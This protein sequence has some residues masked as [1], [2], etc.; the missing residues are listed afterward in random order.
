MSFRG[1]RVWITGASSGIGAALAEAFAAEGARL[2]LSGRRRDALAQVAARVQPDAAILPFDATDWAALPRVAA[3]AGVIDVLVNNAG[4]SQRSLAVDTRPE[5]Y[6]T[7]VETD[8]LAPIWLTQLVLPGMAARRSGHIIGISS[9]AGR[10]GTVLRTGY[11]A[12]KHG[13]IG[14]LDALRAEVEQ[15]YGISVTTVLPGSVRTR[16]AANALL[17]DGSAR[18]ASDPNIEAG[19]DP[20]EC[21]RRILAG[22]AAGEREILVAQGAEAH[23][24]ALRFSDPERLFDMLA[25]EGARLAAER[26]QGGR[27]EPAPVSRT[28]A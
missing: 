3:E 20:A 13:L 16:V 17:A 15:A 5:V 25:R 22:I 4:I 28:I 19:M 21:A 12:A 10:I 6:R 23:A 27:P 9:V 11:C 2:V 1:K 7:I 8:L 18:G 26:E 14:Y 24:A